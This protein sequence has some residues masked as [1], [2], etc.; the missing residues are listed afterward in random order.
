MIIGGGFV[1]SLVAKKLENRFKVTLIDNKDC[2][3]FTPGVP[4]TLVQPEHKKSIQ[5]KHKNYLKKATIINDETISIGECFVNTKTKKLFFD[6][7]V[8]AS[9]SSYSSLLSNVVVSTKADVLSSV[10]DDL[11]KSKKILIIGGGFV[12]V[13]VAGEICERFPNKRLTLVHAQNRLL[14]RCTGKAQEYAKNQLTKKGVEIIF[15]ELITRN[16]GNIFHTNKGRKIKADIAFSCAGIIPNSGFI[17][18]E[19]LKVGRG[20][21]RVN[22]YLQMIGKNNVFVGGDVSS[23][24][25]EKLAQV[26]QKH[27]KIIARNIIFSESNKKLVKYIPRSR[28]LLISLGKYKGILTY[29]NFTLTGIIPAFMKIL[30]EW[31]SMIKYK[32]WSKL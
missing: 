25:E 9:G 7:L 14:E 11:K 2:F 3:E 4:R 24:K 20:F 29:N 6:Y 15:N 5:V 1:G 28:P 21:I 13:E 32:L 17:R 8:I 16:S 10:H 19:S 12:G 31:K 23:V 26:A 22:D 30:V 27:A 18:D